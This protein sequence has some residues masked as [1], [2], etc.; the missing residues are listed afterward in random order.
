MQGQGIHK[1]AVGIVFAAQL[2]QTEAGVIGAGQ[3][4]VADLVLGQVV[5]L[6]LQA[7]FVRKGDGGDEKFHIGFLDY[8]LIRHLMDPGAQRRHVQTPVADDVQ[9][10]GDQ[11]L[12]I[13]QVH[14]T[15]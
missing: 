1:A 8:F 2:F 11:L 14:L 13:V 9:G 5:H 4:H 10:L 7:L 12:N 3:Q 6:H 15:V